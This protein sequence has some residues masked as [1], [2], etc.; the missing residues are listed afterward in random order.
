MSSQVIKPRVAQ[1]ENMIKRAVASG[2]NGAKNSCAKCNGELWIS[3]FFDGTGNDRDVDIPGRSTSNVTG[4]QRAHFDNPE[5]GYFA[6]YYDGA[7]TGFTF[8]DRY[9]TRKVATR[10]GPLTVEEKGY[11]EDNNTSG[12]A[13]GKGMDIRIEKAIFELFREIR[14]ANSRTKINTVHLAAFG[15]SRGSA[16]ARSFL[17]WLKEVSGISISGQTIKYKNAEYKVDCE[18]KFEFLGIFDTVESVGL[19]GKNLAKDT[20]PQ[21]I[22]DFVKQCVHLVAAHEL[23][24]AFPLTLIGKTA[25]KVTTVVYPGVHSNVG[26]GYG[27][28][29]QHKNTDLSKIIAIEM[30]NFARG[31]NLKF[32]SVGEMKSSQDDWVRAYRD[33]FGPSPKSVQ[34]FSGYM[35]KIKSTGKVGTDILAHMRL[36]WAYMNTGAKHAFVEKNYGGWRN[37]FGSMRNLDALQQQQQQFKN[38]VTPAAMKEMTNPTAITANE[39]SFFDT[40]VHDSFENFAITGVVQWDLSYPNYY[41]TRD[42]LTDA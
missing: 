15:F 28:N 16:T 17:H 11:V 30:L 22:P 33:N 3:L 34:L 8:E 27:Q 13:F 12:M 36:Y 7:G 4:L 26:G 25:A 20:Y 6:F 19:A 5:K 39:V 31:A 37:T 41:K 23:R 24:H 35:Q 21:V 32:L 2:K 29:D 14:N 40:M 1:V 42:L 38:N 9:T 10:A 18:I